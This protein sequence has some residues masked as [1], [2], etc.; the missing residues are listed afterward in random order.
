M[1]RWM[2][3]RE[4]AA[5][6]R[7]SVSSLAHMA[8]EG[9]GPRFFKA[10][11]KVRYSKEDLDCWAMGEEFTP[12]PMKLQNFA[13]QRSRHKANIFLDEQKIC[14]QIVKEALSET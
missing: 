9:M 7:I 10:G 4:A 14:D 5:Y 8:C 6:L 3:R 12:I 2:T 13:R 1:S 11:G